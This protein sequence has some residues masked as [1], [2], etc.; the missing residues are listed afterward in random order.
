MLNQN[1]KRLQKSV[2]FMEYPFGGRGWTGEEDRHLAEGTTSYRAHEKYITWAA[3]HLKPLKNED[4][5]I[6]MRTLK[7]RVTSIWKWILREID[8]KPTRTQREFLENAMVVAGKRFGINTNPRED[9]VFLGRYELTQ[10]L[11]IDTQRCVRLDFAENH[12]LTWVLACIC[13]IRPGSL[14]AVS[15][16]SRAEKLYPT[17]EDVKI[18]RGPIAGSFSLD[19]KFRVLKGENGPDNLD[20]KVTLDFKITSPTHSDHLPLSPPH[21]L[22]AIALRRNLLANYETLDSLLSGQDYNILIKPE[23]AAEP[24]MIGGRRR[25]FATNPTPLTARYITSKFGKAARDA[26]YGIEVTMYAWRRK[27]ATNTLRAVGADRA[28]RALN[29]KRGTTTLGEH[30]EQ[31]NFDLPVMAIALGSNVERA[32]K[33][34]SDISSPA[35]THFADQSGLP[36]RV[37]ELCEELKLTDDQYI[38]AVESN[39]RLGK[40][41]AMERIKRA[42]KEMAYKQGSKA[43]ADALTIHEVYARKRDLYDIANFMRMVRQKHGAAQLPVCLADVDNLYDYRD[44]EEMQS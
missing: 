3:E 14:G 7:H 39:N 20:E 36:A 2:R 30:Y 26:G 18:T 16:E 32:Q 38:A 13:G 28:R 25:D 31:G 34:M 29:H 5:F 15:A 1:Q 33:E 24:I 10:L 6:R 23:R 17:W 22:L 43:A 8:L 11:Q 37:E 4:E 27:T 9:Q 21:R 19:I 42:A 40:K 12:H 41:A 44:A 35:L